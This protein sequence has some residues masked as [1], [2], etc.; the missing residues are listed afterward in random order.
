[1]GAILISLNAND[2]V[3]ISISQEGLQTLKCYK[4]I[5]HKEGFVSMIELK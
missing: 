1:M 4:L 5:L 2:I 3:L